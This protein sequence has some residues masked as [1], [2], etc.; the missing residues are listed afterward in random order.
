MRTLF[1]LFILFFSGLLLHGQNKLEVEGKVKISVVDESNSADS[2]VVWLADST[3]ARRDASTLNTSGWTMN[4]D[5][6]Y[7]LKKY[8]G[9][10]TTKPIDLQTDRVLEMMSDDEDSGSIIQ[11]SNKDRSSFLRLFSGRTGDPHPFLW[12]K[13]GGDLRFITD[14]GGYNERFRINS[15]GL[16]T[17]QNR[18]TNVTD[19]IDAQDVVTKAYLDNMLLSFGISLGSVGIQGLLD[20]GYCPLELLNAGAEK[21]SLYGKTYQG[22]LIFYLDDQDTIAGM[23]GLV[24]APMDQDFVGGFTRPWGCFGTDLP[25]PNVLVFPPSG[26]GAEI[27]DGVTNTVG[28]DTAAC[29]VDG[30]AAKM[31]ASLSLNGF[32]D[33]FLPSANE[34]DEIY[35]KIGPGAPAPNTNIGGFAADFYWSSTENDANFAWRQYFNDGNQS[36]SGKASFERVRAVRAI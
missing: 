34:L 2:V 18:I 7:T 10:G 1:I 30:D 26:A 33:W 25:I 12:W 36:T 21:D 31:C 19:P 22:G 3:L 24:S 32:D 6:T 23:K 9:I 5:T 13:E 28:I 8:V 11:M 17:A 14:E 16:V 20:A 35:N 15:D 29:S 4:M 27:G